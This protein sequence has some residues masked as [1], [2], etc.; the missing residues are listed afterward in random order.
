MGLVIAASVALLFGCARDAQSSER[1]NTGDHRRTVVLE[2]FTSQGCSSCPPADELLSALQ[3]EDFDGSTVLPLAYHVDYWNHLGWSDPFS[4]REWS[5]RQ[6][7]YA[8]AMKSAQVYTPQLVINGSLQ[9][10]GSASGAIRAAIRRELDSA[11]DGLVTIDRAILSNGA[12]DVS[13]HSRLDPQASSKDATLL[14]T[15]FENG[16][17]TPVTSGENARRTLRND[18]IVRWQKS[19]TEVR[20][21]AVETQSTVRIPLNGA[22]EPRNLGVVAFLQ[23][24][25]TLAIH[26]SAA[27]GVVAK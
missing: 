25:S 24:P 4:A 27:R 26:A 23:D 20:A 6:S 14:V 7:A 10:V 19:V 12:I 16:V 15:L 1:R 17:T 5:Q 18:A 3:K 2:L 11:D 9:L 22:W 13:L 8:R 21:G